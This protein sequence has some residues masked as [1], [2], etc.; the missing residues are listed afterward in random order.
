MALLLVFYGAC[1][2][3]AN[4]M[5]AGLYVYVMHL[6]Q[7]IGATCPKNVSLWTGVMNVQAKKCLRVLDFA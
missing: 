6:K 5:V 1:V 4:Q 2:C 7:D 3:D